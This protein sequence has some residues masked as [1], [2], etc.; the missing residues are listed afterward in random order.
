MRKGFDQQGAEHFHELVYLPELVGHRLAHAPVGQRHAEFPQPRLGGQDAA[1]LS[2]VVLQRRGF[3]VG[4][5]AHRNARGTVSADDQLGGAL[6]GEE[7]R[8][9]ERRAQEGGDLGERG[10]RQQVLENILRSVAVSEGDAEAVLQLHR[11]EKD[12]L[13]VGRWVARAAEGE[14]H[15]RPARE[16]VVEQVEEFVLGGDHALASGESLAACTA[17]CYTSAR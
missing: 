7:V 8:A 15:E 5:L 6:G 17:S 16:G 3:P 9:E 13:H 2:A 11:T 10:R 1:R 14:L 4:R 12:V